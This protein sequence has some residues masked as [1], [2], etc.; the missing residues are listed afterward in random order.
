MRGEISLDKT[1]TCGR[2]QDNV[3]LS[4]IAKARSRFLVRNRFFAAVGG[5]SSLLEETSKKRYSS[6]NVDCRRLKRKKRKRKVFAEHA[7][8]TSTSR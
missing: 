8:I 3:S 6:R 1:D 4:N 2:R 5:E 7:I